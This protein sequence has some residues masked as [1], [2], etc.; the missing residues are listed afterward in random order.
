M[1]GLQMVNT[2]ELAIN[3]REVFLEHC[4]NLNV[5]YNKELIK[6]LLISLEN[7]LPGA[8]ISMLYFD[9]WKDAYRAI[10]T[11]SEDLPF[12]IQEIVNHSFGNEKSNHQSN[13][14]STTI[15][16]DEFYVFK[17]KTESVKKPFYLVIQDQQNLL[18]DSI[19]KFTCRE[20]E[21][22]L[23][24]YSFNERMSKKLENS[25]ILNELSEKIYSTSSRQRALTYFVKYFEKAYPN[26]KYEILLSQDYDAICDLPVRE[27]NFDYEGERVVDQAFLTGEIKSKVKD[28]YIE[29][30]FPLRGSQ[31]IYGVLV[32]VSEN[33]KRIPKKE[34]DTILKFAGICGQSLE[35]VSLYQHSISLV[36]DLKLINDATKRLNTNTDI[37]KLTSI[38]INQIKEASSAEEI[39]VLLF[40]EE[41]KGQEEFSKG[42]TSYFQKHNNKKFISDLKY[43]CIHNSRIFS[44]NFSNVMKEAPFESIMALPMIHTD[45]HLGVI[46][47]MH[48][49]RYFFSFETFKLVQSLVQHYTLTISNAILKNKLEEAVITDYLTGLYARNYLDDQTK[50]HMKSNENGVLVLFDIDDFKEINDT[51]GHNVGDQVIVQIARVLRDKVS[52]QDIAARWG[53]EELALYLP[54]RSITESYELAKSI[55]NTVESITDPKVTLS[56]G[57]SSWKPGLN[58]SVKELFICT[59][60]ALYEAKSAGKNQIKVA[61]CSVKN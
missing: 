13:S 25:Q 24:M 12:D 57:I 61:D 18:E 3:V 43:S 27:L 47:I 37:N 6:D 40:E 15:L 9:V 23:K 49:K 11:N 14:S 28:D 31:G 33:T 50:D 60:Q 56:C 34:I 19:L 39:G 41:N 32:I 51:Y 59:D 46:I 22:F 44:G 30:Y 54:N 29:M 1:G 55:L 58:D 38:V 10:R 45:Q 42:S 21:Q 16:K 8:K 4:R 48:R 53:G 35:N 7:I 20:F 2:K 17:Y 36:S 52:D 26:L 5:S